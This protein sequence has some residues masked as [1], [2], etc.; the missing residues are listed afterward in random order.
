[1]G[2]YT[3]YKTVYQQRQPNRIQMNNKHTHT[4]SSRLISFWF[5]T[6]MKGVS[7]AHEFPCVHGSKRASEQVSVS[8]CKRTLLVRVVVDNRTPQNWYLRCKCRRWMDCSNCCSWQA[9]HC[10]TIRYLY[11]C[12]RW[13]RT[14]SR[15]EYCTIATETSKFQKVTPQ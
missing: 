12:I 4:H 1:M 14:T 10:K 11:I 13:Y 9:N 15:V 7:F 6:N 5:K 3:K 2:A 8:M